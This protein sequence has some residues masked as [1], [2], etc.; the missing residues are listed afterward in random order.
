MCI[1]NDHGH[2]LTAKTGWAHGLPPVHE[3]EATALLTAIQWIVTLSLPHVTLESDCKSVLDALSRTQSHHSEYGSLLNKC[4]R[5]LHNHPNLSLKF[6]LRQ[7]N[8]V[9]HCLA[10][11]SRHYASSHTFEF[12]P[13]CIVPIILNEMT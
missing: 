5:L 1:R 7:A 11:A 6:I 4:R 10:R 8:R 2:F 13:S 12:I 3:A 9:A